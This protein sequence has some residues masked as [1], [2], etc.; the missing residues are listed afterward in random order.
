MQD[1]LWWFQVSTPLSPPLPPFPSWCPSFRFY[2]GCDACEGWYHP[3]C[4]NITQESVINPLDT[5]LLCLILMTNCIADKQRQWENTSVLFVWMERRKKKKRQK[6]VKGKKWQVIRDIGGLI[7]C[8]PLSL[9]LFLFLD[10][11]ISV[12]QV[13]E[14]RSVRGSIS[15]YFRFPHSSNSRRFDLQRE[16]GRTIQISSRCQRISW[17]S[18]SYLP[19]NG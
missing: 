13:E 18:K 9:D 4:V 8:L 15:F 5:V 14:K 10:Q 3:A 6:V 2:V 11:S 1:S 16:N 17:L 12:E 19:S 7:Q